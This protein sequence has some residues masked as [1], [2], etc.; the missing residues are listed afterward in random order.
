MPEH[1]EDHGHYC[2]ACDFEQQRVERWHTMLDTIDGWN[3]NATPYEVA[4]EIHD[5]PHEN[6]EWYGAMA[7]FGLPQTQI[8][9]VQR[10]VEA[11]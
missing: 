5:S 7:D 3:W 1:C 2:P 10:L 6:E 9:E 4:R 11:L 8:E